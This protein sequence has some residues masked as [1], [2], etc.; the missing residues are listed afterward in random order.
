MAVSLNHP[1]SGLTIQ[2][3][4]P[5]YVW[6]NG[7]S[8]FGEECGAIDSEQQFVQVE[9]KQDL[10]GEIDSLDGSLTSDTEEDDPFQT[11]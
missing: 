3:L 6:D 10:S 11:N 5:D 8:G 7:A 1:E 9:E 2:D 4:H